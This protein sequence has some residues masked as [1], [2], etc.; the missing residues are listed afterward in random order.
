M[1]IFLS[2]VKA[3]VVGGLLCVIGQLLI[4]FTKLTPARILTVFVVAG[5]VLTMLGLYEP[6]VKFAGA[7]ATIPIV[8]FGYSLARGAVKAI[9]E[10]GILGIFTGGITATAAGLAAA[11]FFGWLVSIIFKPSA[12]N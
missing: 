3:F 1:E 12:K 7:G 9:S 11:I 5:V 4:D 2:F 6:V 8:G 10:T